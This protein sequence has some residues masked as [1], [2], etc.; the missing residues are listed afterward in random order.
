MSGKPRADVARL[1]ETIADAFLRTHQ[2]RSSDDVVIDD[3]LN[4]AFVAACRE[5]LPG[6]SA[7][8]VNRRLLNLRKRGKLGRVTATRVRLRDFERFAH[9]AE[10][11]AR[12]M[13]DKY[14]LTV[15]TIFCDPRRRREFDRIARSIVRGRT[16]YEYRRAA[17]R[18]RKARRLAPEPIKHLDAF[19]SEMR[20]EDARL[21]EQHP[22]HVPESPG[23]YMFLDDT[24]YLYIGESRNLRARLRQHLD[25]SDSRSLA[26]YLWERGTGKVKIELQIFAADSEGAR[27]RSRK[28]F[29]AALIA[30]RA[31]R[32]NIQ[33]RPRAHGTQGQG[34]DGPQPDLFR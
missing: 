7:A 8:D 6:L 9:A 34:H 4:A 18:L 2:G 15:D 25:H 13:E 24:G 28:A 20:F 19:A 12:C 23:I 14:G 26:R 22:E 29:E 32:F 21:L 5:Q 3:E 10:I 33:S 17:L 31:P 1:D 30:S 27:T 16:S 11:A